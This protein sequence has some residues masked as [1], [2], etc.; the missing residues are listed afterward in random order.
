M[1]SNKS[2]IDKDARFLLNTLK[3]KSGVVS[4]TLNN[5]QHH[6]HIVQDNKIINLQD[7]RTYDAC[8]SHNISELRRITRQINE[9]LKTCGTG[10]IEEMERLRDQLLNERKDVH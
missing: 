5:W 4:E 6:L 3:R 1:G 2:Q 9:C 7:R 10:N 8:I